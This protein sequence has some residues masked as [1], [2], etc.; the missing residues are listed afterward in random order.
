MK[1]VILGKDGWGVNRR[2]NGRKFRILAPLRE[3]NRRSYGRT[4]YL[5][6]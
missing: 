6:K 1:I 5:P 3:V 4:S 2:I